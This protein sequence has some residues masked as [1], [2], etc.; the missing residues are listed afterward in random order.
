[1]RT[2]FHDGIPW[3]YGKTVGRRYGQNNG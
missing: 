1:M 3:Y 2:D